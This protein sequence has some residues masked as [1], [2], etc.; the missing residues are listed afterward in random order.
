M[1]A[2]VFYDDKGLDVRVE[3]SPEDMVDQAEEYREKLLDAISMF[4]DEIMEMYME[5]EEIPVEKIKA[6][7]RQATLDGGC[8]LGLIFDTDVDRSS[9]VDEQGREISR[10]GIVA[11]AAAL[12]AEECPGTTVVTDSITSNELA[13]YLEGPLGLKHLRFKRGYRNV[14]NKSIALNQAGIDSALAIETSGHAAY[15]ENYFLDDG[16]YLATKIVIRTALLHQQGKPISSLIAD[17]AEPA[18]SIEVRMPITADDFS[19][20]A[21]KALAAVSNMPSAALPSNGDALTYEVVTPNYEGVRI[22]FDM[23]PPP[24]CSSAGNDG[25][26]EKDRLRGWCLLR[27]SLHDPLLPLNV[28]SSAKG[29]CKNIYGLLYSFLSQYDTLDLAPLKEKL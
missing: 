25:T 6:A 23:D 26:E 15:R 12:I 24:S 11:M 16:A 5:G 29:G 3:E 1:K 18:E 22:A 2:N 19:S 10:N 13:A 4:D 28:E 8:D 27:K 20:C 14:I 7:I 9:A 21:D 17:L